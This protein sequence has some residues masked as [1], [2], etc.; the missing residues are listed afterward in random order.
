MLNRTEIESGLEQFTGTEHYY[1]HSPGFVL[2]DGAKWLAE[3]AGC[4]WLYDIAWSVAQKPK[5]RREPFWTLTL[6]TGIEAHKGKVK[7][8]DGNDRVLYVQSIPYTDFPLPTITLFIEADGLGSRVILLP[9]E[10]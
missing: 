2:T 6:T 7:I 9:G 8:T 5:L 10:H 3:S 4:Y 1:R